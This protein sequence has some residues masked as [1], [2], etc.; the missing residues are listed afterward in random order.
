MSNHDDAFVGVNHLVQS[1]CRLVRLVNR[2]TCFLVGFM[3]LKAQSHS[4]AQ[5][6]QVGIANVLM[7]ATTFVPF[8][9]LLLIPRKCVH[10]TRP[11]SAHPLGYN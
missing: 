3:Q 4:Q 10:G 7:H 8:S 2:C 11:I 9:R 1:A 6:M 5:S